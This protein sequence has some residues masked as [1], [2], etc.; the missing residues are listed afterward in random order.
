[1]VAFGASAGGLEAFQEILQTLPDDTGLAYVFIQHLDP[2]HVSILGELLSRCTRMPVVQV[3][4]RMSIEGNKVFVIPPNVGMR[5]SMNKLLLTERAGSAPHMPIDEFFRSLAEEQGN[6]AI[7]VVLS[8]TASD[9]TLGL[10]AVK[11]VGGITLAQDE[12]ARFDAMPRNA[13]AAGWVDLVLSPEAIAR[14]ILRLCRHPYVTTEQAE[15]EAATTAVH[16][17]EGKRFTEIFNMLRSATGVD[18]SLYKL[19]TLQRRI[20]R[21]MALH[22]LESEEQY[23]RYLN[24]NKTELKA[25]FQD[26]LISVTG[27]FR[28]SATFDALKKD[29]LPILFRDRSPE[30]PVRVWVPGCSTGEEAYSIA[31]CLLEHMRDG[32]MEV[33]IQIFGTDLSEAAL[34]R[35]RAGL[36]PESISADISSERLRRF[37]V[38]A[39]GQYQISRSVRD[40]VIFAQHNLTKD[41]PFSKLDLVTCRNVLIYLG[42]AFQGKVMRFFHYALKPTGYLVLGLSESVGPSVD[43]F[44]PVV[45]RLRIYGRKPGVASL[46]HMDFGAYDAR[47]DVGAKRSGPVLGSALELQ[48]RM[49]HY[50]LNRYSPPCVV[51]DE[52]GTILQF[53][54]RTAPYLEHATGEP[55]MNIAGMLR[56]DLAL[57]FRKLFERARKKNVT[58]RGDLVRVTY[59]DRVH[60][61]RICITPMPGPNA[62]PQYLIL[63]EEFDS[64]EPAQRGAPTKP[65]VA[66]QRKLKIR[67]LQQ[68]LNTTKQHLEA[69]VEEY[70]A[71]TEELKSANEEV[72]SSNEELQSTNEELLTAK[73]E[74]QSTNEE[75][76]TVNEEM[77]SRNTELSQI[78]NDLNNLLSSVNIPIVM[79]G[80]DLRI[81]RF[82]PQAEKV[83]NLLSTD[84]GRPVSDFKPKIDIPDLEQLF[85]DVIENLR[86][87]E[88]EVQDRQGRWFS[89]WIRPYR[90]AENRINGAVMVLFDIT[91]RKQAAE[92]RYRRLFEAAK[93]GILIVD[94]DS[95]EL[96]DL[97]PFMA[98][99]FGI[100]RAASIG[101]KY[102]ELDVF[103][104][105]ELGPEILQDLNEQETIQRTLA[106]TTRSGERLDVELIATLYLESQHRAVQFNLRDVTERK[107]LEEST[108]RAV[109]Q[110]QHLHRIQATG[111]LAGSMAPELNNALTTL[112]ICAGLLRKNLAAGGQTDE[113]LKGMTHVLERVSRLNRQLLSFGTPYASAPEILNPNQT[114][115]DIERVIRTALPHTVSLRVECAPD[116]SNVYLDPRQLGEVLVSLALSAREAMPTGGEL[117]IQTKN[118]QVG[119][120]RGIEHHTMAPGKY[121]EISVSY[122]RNSRDPEGGAL[123]EPFFTSRDRRNGDLELAAIANAIRQ[124][125]GYI[126]GTSELGRGA[127][128]HIYFPQTDEAPHPETTIPI[129]G[130]SETVLVVDA[131]DSVRQLTARFLRSY[132]YTALESADSADA[133]RL[134]EDHAGSV[135]LLLT[136]VTA[137]GD[138]GYRLAE[139]VAQ[140][141]PKTRVLYMSSGWQAAASPQNGAFLLKPFAPED[142]LKQ[143]RRTL[144]S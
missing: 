111:D 83:L 142:L 34:D 4:H 61:T 93:D 122:S 86:I 46:N 89:M 99:T 71:T 85:L 20:L 84:V 33:P 141:S 51:I 43:L 114:L 118:Q 127:S 40:M 26:I 11:A 7:A 72:Q 38:K 135:H 123:L 144:D 109:E 105:T 132:G 74:L 37:F 133:A 36:Y 120:E 10:K 48:R 102:W 53:H 17:G 76:T 13:I 57:S 66:N 79:L 101:V 56:S 87:K 97:N 131:D 124:S 112:M 113:D 129:E 143:V 31:I 104:G 42:P 78:N 107:R 16:A 2:K 121:A 119:G 91:E 69:V 55:A 41:P 139:R 24:E 35:A 29:I 117:A 8:G 23:V 27:F 39:D 3:K 52:R 58:A 134:V 67:D 14:E 116:L 77:H 88:R 1:V 92:A 108:R 115:R 25:L 73:E 82:T 110:V 68:E 81:R 128:I 28:E 137:Q 49:D 126:W 5:L 130:G 138:S 18:F 44:I 80:N 106:L 22:K 32:G 125:G 103:R 70:E 75:L 94:A 45:K 95:G 19:G 47:L 15:S 30:N 90:T 63:F 50:L 136:E 9:G 59:R 12:T 21:R 140:L 96:L 65:G 98:K 100:A 62:E 60:Q 54:G 6:R 64:D